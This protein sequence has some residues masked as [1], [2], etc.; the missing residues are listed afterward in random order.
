MSACSEKAKD[1]NVKEKKSR[2]VVPFLVKTH[3]MVEEGETDDVI[4][5]GATGK[6]FVVWKPLEFARD[7]LPA[8]FKHNN[9]SSFVRQLNTYG[10]RKVVPDRWEFENDK[11]LQGKQGLLSEIRRRRKAHPTPTTDR[12]SNKQRRRSK[13]NTTNSGEVHSSPSTS[14]PPSP[15]QPQHYLDLL[16]DENKK[17]K[18]DNHILSTELAEAK[19]Q[20]EELLGALSKHVSID[21]LNAS[22][23]IEEAASIGIG[24]STGED[25]NMTEGD[26]DDDDNIVEEEGEEVARLKVFGVFLKGFEGEKE[27]TTTTG[28][29]KEE[30][31]GRREERS[32]DHRPMKKMDLRAP[33]MQMSSTSR[34][35]SK[36]C[37]RSITLSL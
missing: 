19:K 35:S 32:S 4:S 26:D 29:G 18:K 30:K 37:N 34:E 8:H 10:F 9:F 1:G 2:V 11:F 5:W 21:E 27:A 20:C 23:L 12:S 13:N 6:S 22:L 25:Y 16:I 33:W 14:P 24:T 7:L 36:A 28:G 3:Q 31:R 15:P 17:L